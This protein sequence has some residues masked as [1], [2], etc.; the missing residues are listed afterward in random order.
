MGEFLRGGSF[1]AW[2]CA[3]LGAE[4]QE[5]EYFLTMFSQPIRVLKAGDEAP[6]VQ[7]T[8]ECRYVSLGC[9]SKERK[10]QVRM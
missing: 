5:L 10:W 8:A 6:A 4:C 1:W 9:G 3:R 2:C 7:K